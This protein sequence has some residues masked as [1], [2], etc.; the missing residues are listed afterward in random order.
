MSRP[1]MSALQGFE[2]QAIKEL[3]KRIEA[4]GAASPYEDTDCWVF[5][6]LQDIPT[7]TNQ[8][9][10][11]ET[12]EVAAAAREACSFIDV[13]VGYEAY[14]PTI[15]SLWT[16]YNPDLQVN[17]PIDP[18]FSGNFIVPN[19]ESLRGETEEG[20]AFYEAIHKY[21]AVVKRR[22]LCR[23]SSAAYM[24]PVTAPPGSENTASADELV[25]A[26]PVEEVAAAGTTTAPV[27]RE[28]I[29]EE[30]LIEADVVD[31]TTAAPAVEGVVE[32]IAPV[33]PYVE[34]PNICCG[35]GLNGKVY[36]QNTKSCCENG[37]V[38][39]YDADGADQCPF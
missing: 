37:S 15:M 19:A 34:T 21:M 17:A 20:V 27:D 7:D 24:A 31:A 14:D 18:D 30:E 16:V 1:S 4:N 10:L 26:G 25:T 5:R 36:D 35:I 13:F 3:A 23:C 32:E 11:T 39:P 12:Q 33:D 9:L 8:F 29:V 38:M 2:S 6:F 28:L 22:Q